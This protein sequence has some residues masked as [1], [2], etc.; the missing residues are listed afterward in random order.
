MGNTLNKPG[1][2]LKREINKETI[3]DTNSRSH[4]SKYG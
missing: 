2:L 1:I 4:G 3:E